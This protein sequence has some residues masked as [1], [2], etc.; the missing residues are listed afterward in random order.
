MN[1]PK[2]R[3]K[4][5]LAAVVLAGALSACAL[6]QNSYLLATPDQPK[7]QAGHQAKPGWATQGFS[8]AAAHPLAT[9]AGYQVLKAGGSAI[10]AAIAVQMVLTLVEPQ[11]S[12]IGGGAFVLHHDGKKV[13]AYDGREVAPSAATDKLFL[14]TQGKPLPFME[15]VLSGLSVGV[16]GTLSVLETAHKEHGKLPWATLMQPAIQLAEQGFKISPRLHQALLAENDLINDAVAASYFYDAQRK[17]HPVGYVLKNPEL[18]AVLRDIANRGSL[19]LK[20]GAVAQALVQKVRQHPTKPGSMTLQDLAQYKVIKREP[21][22]F[23]HVVQT[24]SKG[25]QICGFPPPSSGALAIG[26]ILGILNNTP[27]GK[28]PLQQGLPASEWLHFYTEAARLA[29]ADRAQFVGDPDFVKAP[30]GNWKSMLH[31]TYLQQ[32]SRLIGEQ[33]MKVAKAGNPAEF[34]T[35]YAPMPHQDE[36]GTSHISVIDQYGNSVA[37]T[38][39][40]EAVFGSRLMVNTGQG[41]QGGFLL[42]NE[43]TDFSFAPSDA[44]G[45]PIA[46]RVEAGK[47][48]RSSMSPTLV[49][50]KDTG[51]LKMTGGSPGGAVIIHYTGKLLI[52]T[53]QWGLNTQQ[54]INLPNF[55][56]LNGPTVLEEKRFP[57]Q[58]LKALQ[59]RGHEVREMPLPSGLQA[60]EV[61]PKGFFGGADP[62]REGVVMGPKP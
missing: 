7:D 8:V 59:A 47:R 53:L 44:K 32:R 20:Q 19:A 41:R 31:P 2:S 42:N 26:Q 33:S 12:G 3:S 61:T 54:A 45:L 35:A 48:P 28:M 62:R 37:M 16:P 25:F 30:S 34:K 56:S 58:T 52:G 60:I 10:D 22:C 5:M 23:D 6:K 15:A 1:F 50:E 36:F 55:G 9:D 38:T 29:F 40:I 17:P 46:N 51:Q 43:L 18:A 14:D 24:T 39:T 49:F 11:S 4:L 21:L 57:E 27:A 13:E